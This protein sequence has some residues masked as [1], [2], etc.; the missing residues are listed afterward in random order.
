MQ[1]H[2]AS[3]GT[4]CFVL[5]Q[6]AVP[7]LLLGLKKR[8]VGA[9]KYN[10][11]GGKIET[12]ESAPVA[13]A[14]ELWEEAGLTAA[15]TALQAMGHVLFPHAQGRMHLFLATVWQGT[16]QESDEMI[17]CWFPLHALPYAQMW[18]TDCDWLPF[19]LAGRRVEVV[20]HRRPDGQRICEF[21]EIGLC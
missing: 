19:V 6:S 17:P 2:Y 7:R 10:G 21:L 20:V 12:G 1:Y 5:D 9:G 14:R 15:P 18:P 4:V 3:E 8:G 11:F 13:A 16:P